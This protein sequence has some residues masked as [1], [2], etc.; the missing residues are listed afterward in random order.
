MQVYEDGALRLLRIGPLGPFANNA[1][2]VADRQAGEAVLVDMPAEGERVL[3]ALEGLRVTAI[4]LTHTHPD[5][6][7]SYE[8]VKGATNAPVLCHPAEVIMPRERRDGELADGQELA[9]GS[10][11]LKVIHTPGHTPGSCCFLVGRYLLSG[12]TLFPGG[13]GRSNSPQDLQQEIASITQKLYILPDDTLVLPGHG[14][15]TTIGQSKREYAVFA[16][17]PHPPDLCGDVLWES[18]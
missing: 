9:V 4:V 3:A 8:L 7:Q 12:D 16:S 11:R 18:S 10:L 6:W 5:H 2:V 17:R 14:E 1:Y 15:G 13:P